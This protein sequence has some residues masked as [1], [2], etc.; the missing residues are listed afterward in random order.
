MIGGLVFIKSF[1]THAITMRGL[2]QMTNSYFS[3]STVVAH[4]AKTD[5]QLNINFDI[6]K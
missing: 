4:Y 1:I 2:K 6:C 3:P 5:G